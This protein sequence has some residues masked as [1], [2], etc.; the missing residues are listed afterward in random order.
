MTS[1]I[2]AWSLSVIGILSSLFLWMRSSK[3]AMDLD[4]HKK[5]ILEKDVQ[6][7]GKDKLLLEARESQKNLKDS[8]ENTFKALAQDTLSAQT[9]SFL[10]LASERLD[11]KTVEAK[12]VLD[13]R[14]AIFHKLVEPIEKTLTQVRSEISD[15][16][17]KRGE[18]FG[19]ISEQL[20]NVVLSSEGLQKEAQSLS[21][22]LR[23]PEVRG[24]WGEM[25]L[26]RVVEMAGMS[27]HCD[28]EEQVSVKT[29]TSSLRPD[30]V[31]N[32]PNKRILAVDSKA[33]LTAYLESLEVESV[34]QKKILRL[35]HA[36]NI[37]N[38]VKLL[39]RKDYWDQFENSP[40]FLVLF[41]P[42]EG[43]LDAALEVD[44]DL[45]ESA[46]A[47]KVIIATP[48]TLI[49]LLKAVAY[50][51]QQSEMADNAN[52]VIESA[53]E[54]YDRLL[55]WLSHLDKVGT[56]LN[57]SVASF[58]SAV[59]SL[60]TRVLPSAKRLKDLGLVAKGEIDAPGQIDVSPRKLAP[61]ESET[62]V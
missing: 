33:V 56:K 52:R 21:T 5:I 22:A 51:W 32:L 7:Q 59:G 29:E 6:I 45:F 58:N 57:D 47:Q 41:I 1:E 62:E 43:F 15:F 19:H 54:F 16:E 28:F 27:S 17:K 18:Q 25:Q 55:P 2:I 23:R 10:K 40:D 36:Q 4:F 20:K 39:S 35:K 3:I 53:K 49:A 42:N 61:P 11:R 34:E 30:M 12:N 31:I 13:E 46:W 44:R 26:K 37:R 14:T 48:T 38:H 8:V 50:G 24:S 9:E 60:E